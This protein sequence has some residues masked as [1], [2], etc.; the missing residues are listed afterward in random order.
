MESTLPPTEKPRA[1]AVPRD[2]N[3]ATTPIIVCT[4][5]TPSKYSIGFKLDNLSNVIVLFSTSQMKAIL[6]VN[7]SEDVT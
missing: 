4:L 6:A 5:L 1:I 2:K 3:A 7:I